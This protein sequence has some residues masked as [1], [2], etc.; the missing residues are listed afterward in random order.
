[1]NPRVDLL[2]PEVVSICLVWERSSSVEDG[3]AIQ[4]R[5]RCDQFENEKLSGGDLEET[6]E[7]DEVRSEGEK[8]GSKSGR[9][10][11]YNRVDLGVAEISVARMMAILVRDSMKLEQSP[12]PLESVVP[13]SDPG[14]VV[15]ERRGEGTIGVGWEVLG[16][17]VRVGSRE[18]ESE[19]DLVD[20]DTWEG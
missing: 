16:G 7:S 19:A 4:S 17:D 2:E 18:V 9:R 12:L 14:R 10:K 20:V 13:S 15:V 8:K 1:M 6:D 11:T 3:L 5:S